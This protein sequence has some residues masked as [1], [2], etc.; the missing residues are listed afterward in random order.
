[1]VMLAFGAD[2]PHDDAMPARRARGAEGDALSSQPGIEPAHVVITGGSS[3]IGAALAHVY[4]VAGRR[5]S[6]IARDRAR[7]EAV[8]DSG[9]ARGAEVDI[10][11]AD[12][13]DAGA[14]EQA[15]L[16]CDA[17]QPIALLIANAGVGGRDS[18]AP[19]SG[20]GG[21]VARQIFATNALGVI[22]TVTPIL[23]RM[24]ERRHGQ[25]AIMSSLAGLVALPAC[26]AY[27]ASKAAIRA[28]GTALRCLAAPSGVHISVICPGFIDTPMSAN[29]PFRPPFLWSADR[30]ARHIARALARGRR[31]IVFPWPLALA[32]HAINL[33]PTALADRILTL[34]AAAGSPRD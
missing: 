12:V 33:L 23:P 1:M 34:T 15:V 32:V 13:A 3:G 26:P 5:V 16:A 29:L 11:V 24:I 9:R 22:N 14:I 18:L 4:G 10:H 8:A 25:I 21:A 28:Y 20:E 27:S 2:Q 17:R 19:S 6:L 7:L 31:E 30:A